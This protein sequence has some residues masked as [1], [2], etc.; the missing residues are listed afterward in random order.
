M[1]DTAKLKRIGGIVIVVAIVVVIATLAWRRHQAIESIVPPPVTVRPA[2]SVRAVRADLGEVQT[3]LIADGTAR[4]IRREYLTFPR[5]GRIVYLYRDADGRELREGDAVKAGDVLAYQDKRT[6]EADVTAAQAKVTM[7]TA[8]RAAATANLQA[9]K[10]ALTEAESRQTLAA[11]ELELAKAEELLAQATFRRFK[12]LF[13]QESASA[14][15]FDEAKA[16]VARASASVARARSQAQVA[17]SQVV[18]ASSQIDSAQS[19]IYAVGATLET[20]AAQVAQASVA[21][22][23]TELRS[24]IDG[25]AAYVNIQPGYLFTPSI[26]R[27]DSESSALQTVPIVVI[28]PTAFEI[29]VNVPSYEQRRLAVG[30]TVRISAGEHWLDTPPEA[31]GSVTTGSVSGTVYAITPAI[32]PGGRSVQL[33]VRTDDGA[34]LLKDGMYVTVWIATESRTDVIVAPP[35]ALL[36]QENTPYVFVL[37]TATQVVTR[38]QVTL[39]VQ[40][41]AGTEIVDGLE[42]GETLVTDGRF[43]VTDGAI[44]NRL[45]D[46][47]ATRGN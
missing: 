8:D 29:S 28:D 27:T 18:A 14:Q 38:R 4:S 24:P 16:G 11:D 1:A 45:G 12:T 5:A 26:V 2:T 47:S 9:V 39:G 37:D 42:A 35:D 19:Q 7:A 31:G 10:A 43:Q 36:Y 6:N 40:G 46:S 17:A 30:Q 41:F 23:D 25:I 13:E 32:S 33:K 20:A 22:E 15:E 3:W 21:L 34:K 44:V